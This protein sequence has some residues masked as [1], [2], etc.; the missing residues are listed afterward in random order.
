MERLNCHVKE[1]AWGKKGLDSEVARLYAD[2]HEQ[3]KV[4][5]EQTYAELW[6]GTHPDGAAT[7]KN[8]NVRLSTMIAKDDNKSSFS[9]K[10]GNS[11][12]SYS[13]NNSDEEKEDSHLPFIMKIMSINKTL[14][15]QVHPTKEQAA[16][17]HEKDPINYPDRHHKPELAYALTRFELMC[18]FRPASEIVQNMNA[19]PELKAVMGVSNADYFIKLFNQGYSQESRDLKKALAVAFKHMLLTQLN[20]PEIIKKHLDS[21]INKLKSRMVEGAALMEDTINV[22]L[23]M[24]KDFPGDVGCFALLYLNHMILQPGECCYYA[25]EELHAYLSGECVEC[26]G[27]SNNTIRAALTPKY[28]D[29][30]SLC[31]VLN[32]RMT[33]CSYYIVDPKTLPGFEHVREY[34]PDCKDFTLHEIKI[35]TDE[36]IK[37]NLTTLY[38][39]PALSC[40]SIVVVVEG[41]GVVQDKQPTA[42]EV[43]SL[44]ERRYKRGDIF[45]IPPM[46]VVSFIQEKGKSKDLLAYRTFSYEEGPDHSNRKLTIKTANSTSSLENNLSPP[47][48]INKQKL[49]AFDRKFDTTNGTNFNQQI[50]PTKIFKVESEMDGFC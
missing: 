32:Y 50:K 41:E 16:W 46:Q 11:D 30:D 25:A 47:L 33:D 45:Y 36:T 17:L 5:R 22:I 23:K 43:N 3:F 20:N 35:S 39:L 34:A 38:S 27:C 31:E 21:F 29:I 42:F 2:G 24:E 1:Y 28:I 10:S 26:V 14:S 4:D 8:T 18:G 15:L 13:Y 40:G 37:K 7:V 48:I 19:F 44:N 49:K 9:I 6:M 12:Y